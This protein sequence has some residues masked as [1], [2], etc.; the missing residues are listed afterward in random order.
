MLTI[1]ERHYSTFYQIR[2]TRD[3]KLIAVHSGSRGY[4]N[5]MIARYAQATGKISHKYAAV[6]H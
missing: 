1:T 2:V 6:H 3:D 4:I 5:K